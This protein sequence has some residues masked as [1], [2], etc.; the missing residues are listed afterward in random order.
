MFMLHLHQEVRPQDRDRQRFAFGAVRF[1]SVSR[2]VASSLRRGVRMKNRTSAARGVVRVVAAALFVA[3]A[4]TPTHAQGFL[5]QID[6]DPTSTA[7]PTTYASVGDVDDDGADDFVA[8]D[9]SWSDSTH[10]SDGAFYVYSGR[11]Q[12]LLWSITGQGD[13]T[14]LGDSL[15]TLGDL[16]GDGYREFAIGTELDHAP[17]YLTPQ[18][19]VYSPRK[20]AL[21]YQVSLPKDNGYM[22]SIAD[23]GDADLDG[24]SDFV[25][26]KGQTITVVSG[27][28]GSILS[29]WTEQNM[30]PSV[31]GLGD[32]DG[33]GFPDLV[34]GRPFRST[35][36]WVD[37][38]VVDVLSG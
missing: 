8:T 28:T 15:A 21:L 7:F 32:V 6:G 30:A 33:D 5:W 26:A 4:S 34:C 2:P 14:Q 17:P 23:V 29:Q 19:Y 27:A 31:D 37:N 22:A 36:G 10:R 20:Q 11:S 1:S 38:G 24:V 9:M 25:I 12:T 35:N 3:G 13:L 16:D 18:V